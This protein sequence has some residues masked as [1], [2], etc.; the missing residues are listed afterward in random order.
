MT[1]KV[2]QIILKNCHIAYLLA[3]RELKV[4]N[5]GGDL[6]DFFE[7]QVSSGELLINLIPELIG[8]EDALQQVLDGTAPR[9]TLEYLNRSMADGDTQYI[10]VGALPFQKGKT[11]LIV[12][13]DV[14]EQGRFMQSL[15][16]QRNELRL[17]RRELAQANSRLDFLLHHY[18]PPEVA[19]ALIE[20]RILPE[21]GGELRE[22]S[23]LFADLR[24]YTRTAEQLTPGQTMN[25]LNE[26][27]NIASESIA[28]AD[29]T[30]AQFMGDSVMALFNAPNDQPDH[31]MLAVRA[32]LMIQHRTRSYRPQVEKGLPSLHFGVGIHTGIAV[33]GNTGARWRYD[34]SAIGDTTNVAYRITTIAQGGEVLISAATH[35]RVRGRVLVTPMMPVKVK[36][37]SE[38]LPLFHV[39]SLA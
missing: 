19:D 36:G 31:A 5:A 3:D 29:G 8:S 30:I 14:T 25:L 10:T 34:Y 28:D 11:V 6:E 15:A 12:I 35:D 27:L 4:V 23:V 33:V 1:D 26:Y 7:G 17:L 37:K 22:V 13:K 18:I 32:G 9:F 16:Q 39:E 24:G 20:E 38:P 21:P 2:A